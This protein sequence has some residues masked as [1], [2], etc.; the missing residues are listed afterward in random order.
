MQPPVDFTLFLRPLTPVSWSLLAASAVYMISLVI[1]LNCAAPDTFGTRIVS[2]SG[3]I[4]FVVA[5]ANYEGALTMFFSSPRSLDFENLDQALMLYP[6][7]KMLMV[8]GS[9]K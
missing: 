1:L 7:W 6:D 9:G 3:W 4:L 5:K 2:L 8:K